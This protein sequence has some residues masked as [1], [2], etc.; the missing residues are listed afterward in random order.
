MRLLVAALGL[1]ALVGTKDAVL[2]QGPARP[3][4]I[5]VHG[6]GQSS[7][8][9]A[10]LRR[11]WKVDLDSS[12]ALVGMP[13][14][15]D[16]DVRLAWYADVLDSE[17]DDNCLPSRSE[18]DSLTFGDIARGFVG[19]LSSLTP[20]ADQRDVRGVLGDVMF[21]VDPATRCGAQRRVRSAIDAAAREHRPV[22]VIACSL[23]ALVTH[24]YL[25]GRATDEPVRLRLITVG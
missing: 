16:D 3:L 7:Q 17:S 6:R 10:E 4:V 14:L 20:P 8:D 12:L 2:G 9:S 24:D 21:L 25:K 1:A 11:E 23:G 18:T 19:L 13:P 15:R 5:L 22:I